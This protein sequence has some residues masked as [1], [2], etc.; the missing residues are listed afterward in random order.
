MTESNF[1]QA[2]NS[3]VLVFDGAIGTSVQGQNLSIDDYDGHENCVDVVTATRPEVILDIHRSFLSVGCDA[4]LTNTFGANKI[5][6]GDF[7]IADRAR[8]LNRRSAEIAR[9]ACE[10]FDKP[11]RPR[12][13]VG[14][15]GP[16]TRLPSLGQTTWD[17]LVDSYTE[18]VRGLLEGGVDAVLIE[19]C[20]DILQAKSAIVAASDAMDELDRHVPILCTFT[21]ETTGTML[22]GTETAA[23]LT[24]LEAYDQV[25]AIGLNCATGPQEMSEHVRYLSK[26]SSRFL[27]VQP[28]AGL[29]QLVDGKPYYALTPEELARWLI[30]F[31]EVDGVN[32]VG[33]CCGTTP[34]HL[35][36]VVDAVAG[37][38]PKRRRPETEASVASLYQS[39]AIRQD[40]ACLAIG[41]RTNANGSKKFRELLALGDLDGMVQ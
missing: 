33:G 3:R 15:M 31:I 10:A 38:A 32:I 14:S 7:G 30:E 36:A 22:I 27:I 39:V 2:I 29:P 40:S 41:E 18:Q 17:T 21:V 16:G 20:Q 11:G 25:V 37:R 24:A 9:Q 1:I 23:A 5:V 6:L 28:N 19:T 8:K 26:H 13:V 12:F 4:V 34:A 35:A